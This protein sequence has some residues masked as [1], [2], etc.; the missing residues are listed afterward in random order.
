MQGL[1][2][3]ERLMLDRERERLEHD[4]GGIKDMGNLPSLLFVIDTN[5]E[6]NAIKE[7]RRLGIPVVAIIDTNS[8]PDTVDYP[9]PGQRRRLARPRALLLADLARRDRRHRPLVGR[10]R[11]RSRRQRR[12]SGRAGARRADAAGSAAAN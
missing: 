2:K 6:A 10:P 3:K 4:L 8:D 7:A 5:K 11:R 9:D 1:T 12:S